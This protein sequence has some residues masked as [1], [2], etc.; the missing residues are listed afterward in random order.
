MGSL[1]RAKA[2]ENRFSRNTI[3]THA[4]Q[5]SVVLNEK[6]AKEA[7]SFL[8]ENPHLLQDYKA[9]KLCLNYALRESA[10]ELA[11]LIAEDFKE[12]SID[13]AHD[14]LSLAILLGCPL[15][16]DN[17][18]ACHPSLTTYTREDGDTYLHSIGRFPQ[19]RTDST[20][21]AKIAS[22]FI[23]RGADI[24]AEDRF[25]N[26]PLH[27][28]Q[29]AAVAEKLLE[30]GAN[31]NALTT[32]FQTPF[33]SAN[34]EKTTLLIQYGGEAAKVSNRTSTPLWDAVYSASKAYDH[35]HFAE[36]VQ[37]IKLLIGQGCYT[38]LTGWMQ[39][40]KT[41]AEG[42]TFNLGEEKK[43]QILKL[44]EAGKKPS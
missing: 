33:F 21:F 36:A 44:L 2:D 3:T 8:G 22:I 27:T 15:C 18:L 35:E 39:T 23:D 28:T 24:N 42:I 38:D 25:K 32:T 43:E 6:G 37:L 16:V 14:Y 10:D 5:F 9:K 12:T 13:D 29:V 26:T 7:W 30:A 41:Y 19:G 20:K 34:L 31:P 40:A 11:C 4:H 1:F 17:I